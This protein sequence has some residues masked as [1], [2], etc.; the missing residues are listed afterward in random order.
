MVR[1]VLKEAAG[2]LKC[3]V[4]PSPQPRRAHL[5]EH[6]TRWGRSSENEF[7]YAAA[8]GNLTKRE[9]EEHLAK[10]FSI[11]TRFKAIQQS[12]C[13]KGFT[14]TRLISPE[15]ITQLCQMRGY[16]PILFPPLPRC[17]V[18]Y[19][20]GDVRGPARESHWRDVGERSPCCGHVLS[21]SDGSKPA[22]RL[23]GGPDRGWHASADLRLFPC[24]VRI[25][26]KAQCLSAWSAV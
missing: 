2:S 1:R 26:P 14:I 24:Y 18:K 15:F 3:C 22:G 19:A 17:G 11:F 21:V 16:S 6:G 4:M 13:F 7:G 10:T 25:N 9:Q 20:S 23:A 5:R 8:Q 12:L